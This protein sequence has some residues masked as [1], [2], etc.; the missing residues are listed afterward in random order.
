[1]AYLYLLL[2]LAGLLIGSD[3]AVRGSIS[4]AHRW[5]WPGWAT[6][7]LLLAV[8]TSL[9]ELFISIASAP[10]HPG[11]ALGNI[12][13]SNAF[14]VGVV[15]GAALLLKGSAR[16]DV[17]AVRLPTLLPLVFGSLAAFLLIGAPQEIY[18]L[19]FLFLV[20]YG[21]MIR[22]S[23]ALRGD[24]LR[25]D[26]EAAPTKVFNFPLALA[27]TAAGFLL[28]A[29]A[30]TWFLNGA[31][32]IANQLGWK[33]G[34]AGFIITAIGTSAPELFTSVRALK[35]G[36]AGAVFGNVVGSNAFNL[37]VAGGFIGLLA[38]V[39]APQEGLSALV[40]VNMIATLVLIIPGI[41][42]NKNREISIK[43]YQGMGVLLIGGYLAGAFWVS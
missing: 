38:D 6:G 11:L 43:A 13:G 16:L 1:M 4:L 29:F 39:Q 23:I 21:V 19:S 8:G 5:G 2:G 24:D 18:F 32:D 7:L 35:L 15:L 37:L 17:H 34:F 25:E 40:M 41:L 22:L 36:H 3:L 26:E 10:E 30:S 27:L 42:T 9:P 31:L 14:N 28:L 12:F 20:A 33:E